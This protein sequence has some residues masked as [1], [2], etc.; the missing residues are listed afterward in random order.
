MIFSL[1]T[2]LLIFMV[3][4][5][6]HKYPR[7]IHL[8]KYVKLSLMKHFYKTNTIFIFTII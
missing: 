1:D 7:Q 5:L 2:K 4:H 3:I 8:Q 6:L